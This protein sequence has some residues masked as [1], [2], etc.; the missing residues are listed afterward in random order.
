M[1]NLVVFTGA[2]VSAESG[3]K[4]FRDTDGL[5]EEYNVMD[6]ATPEAWEAD[7]ELVLDFYNKRRRQILDAKPNEAHTWI[8]AL[9]KKYL[10]TVI[11]Q[12]I[13]D[14]HERA[15]SSHVLHLHGNITY[16]RSTNPNDEKL[17]PIKGSELSL[18]DTC[19]NGFQMRPHVVWFGE[20]VPNMPIAQDIIKKSEILIICGTSLTVYPAAGLVFHAHY[21][22]KKF[23][24][25]P[26]DIR[27]ADI[28]NIS[29]IKEK[30]SIGMKILAEKLLSSGSIN[31]L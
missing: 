5:W 31:D 9:E 21:K 2:G 19:A 8:A 20:D 1:K 26:N 6:V 23:L 18:G 16:G 15:G 24:I 17:Y 7:K 22:C 13:D 12:N 14:L 3:L 27:L 11:T 30:A 4:T 28:D 29:V 25:D 10:V